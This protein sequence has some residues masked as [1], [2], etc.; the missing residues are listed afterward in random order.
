MDEQI[1]KLIA[2]YVKGYGDK[3]FTK[4][5]IINRICARKQFQAVI[6]QLAQQ[7]PG[8]KLDD[9]YVQYLEQRVSKFLQQKITYKTS[10]GN[11]SVRLYENYASGQGPRRWRT[12]KTMTASDLRICIGARRSRVALEQ[13]TI[14]VYGKMLALLEGKDDKTKVETIF[15]KA[16]AEIASEDLAVEA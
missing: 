5:E 10:S 1:D 14:R 9:I 6:W 16:L 15:D 11:V 4:P 12:L 3:Y 13:R 7:F 8:W 2:Q